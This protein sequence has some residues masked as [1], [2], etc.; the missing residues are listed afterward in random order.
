[1]VSKASGPQ[2]TWLH[3]FGSEV[4]QNLMATGTWWIK[5]I[6]S[7]EA[8]WILPCSSLGSTHS[9][10]WSPHLLNGSTHVHSRSS[11]SCIIAAFILWRSKRYFHLIWGFIVSSLTLY[12]RW[13]PMTF[14]SLGCPSSRTRFQSIACSRRKY[15]LFDDIPCVVF[16]LP[17]TSKDTH[18]LFTCVLFRI[19]VREL[20]CSRVP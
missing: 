3:C 11:I 4:R 19:K 10:V 20:K 14:H 8:G 16:T 7:L 15:N 1:M 9:L 18:L 13:P 6:T 12:F 5:S 2:W 17:H